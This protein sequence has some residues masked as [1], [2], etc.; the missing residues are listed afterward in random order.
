MEF[1]RS[2]KNENDFIFGIRTVIEAI[3]SGKTI[4]KLMI[5]KGLAG[6]LIQE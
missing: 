6:G 4:D 2:K 5:K 3:R 1:L